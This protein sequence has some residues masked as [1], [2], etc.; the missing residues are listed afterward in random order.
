MTNDEAKKGAGKYE[1]ASEKR[2]YVFNFFNGEIGIRWNTNRLG[3]H[4]NDDH[5]GTWHEP[6]QYFVDFKIGGAKL[7]T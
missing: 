1:R 3:A 6:F 7:G 4:V 5:H 2:T